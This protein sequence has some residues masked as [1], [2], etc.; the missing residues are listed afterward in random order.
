MS[1]TRLKSSVLVKPVSAD[2]NLNCDYC[3]YLEKT[4]LYPETKKHR[5]TSEVLERLIQQVMQHT[6]GA[7]GIAWQGGEPTL[8]GLD[9][10]KQVVELEKKYGYSGQIVSNAIQTNGIYLNETW[11]QFLSQY[12]FLV[13][14]SLDGPAELHNFYRKTINRKPTYELI[15]P[16]IELLRR[17]N[18]AF[19]ILMVLNDITVKYPRELYNYCVDNGINH[20][21]FIPAVEL[22]ENGRL[23]AFSIPAEKYGDFLCTLFDIWYNDGNPHLSIRLFDNYLGQLINGKNEMCFFR[24]SCDTYLVVEANGDVY[25]CD[26][27]VE[28]KWKVGNLMKQ[29]LWELE[30]TASRTQFAVYK[31]NLPQ[32]CQQCEWQNYCH[33]GCPKYRVMGNPNYMCDG[34]KQFFAHSMPELRKMA[35]S[36]RSQNGISISRNE[37]CPCGSGK[38]Y[39]TCCG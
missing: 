35:D 9:F 34:Y 30:R 20:V 33:G 16:K 18:V 12:K 25:T 39:K 19:N 32:T 10:F 27:F 3:F 15:Y 22:D 1:D 4:A 8:A 14:L 24:Q 38:K 11:A 31:S 21:Q 37:P 29:P 7:V 5:M 26:F 28:P 2:C 6:T 13:G 17:Y 36:I 23:A